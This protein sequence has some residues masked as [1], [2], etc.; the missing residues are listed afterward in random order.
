MDTKAPPAITSAYATAVMRSQA[1]QRPGNGDAM[2]IN[3]IWARYTTMPPTL[4]IVFHRW[5]PG[6][7]GVRFCLLWFHILV[8]FEK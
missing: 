2:K 8:R 3:C 4:G 1:G 5:E 6:R 7:Y